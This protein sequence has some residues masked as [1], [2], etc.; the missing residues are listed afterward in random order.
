M[1]EKL[2]PCPFCGGKAKSYISDIL[3]EIKCE[4]CFAGIKIKIS[5]TSSTYDD[6]VAKW[7]RWC[8]NA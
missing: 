4:K 5:E 3:I 6:M 1:P 2:K 7:N 8:D